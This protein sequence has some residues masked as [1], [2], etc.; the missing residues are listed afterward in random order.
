MQVMQVVQVVQV[1]Q[2]MQVVQVVQVMQVV[3]VQQDCKTLRQKSN[4]VYPTNSEL[5]LMAGSYTHK[6]VCRTVCPYAV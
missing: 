1:V 5:P 2:V 6:L 3:Q 4:H